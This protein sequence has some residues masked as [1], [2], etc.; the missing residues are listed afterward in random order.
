M[1]NLLSVISSFFL[2]IELKELT[3]YCLMLEKTLLDFTVRFWNTLLSVLSHIPPPPHLVTIGTL[4]H[5]RNNCFVKYESLANDFWAMWNEITKEM[6]ENIRCFLDA[7]FDRDYILLESDLIWCPIPAKN[8]LF[9][10]ITTFCLQHN[11]LYTTCNI[12]HNF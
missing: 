6:M 5:A 12:Q 4:L 7:M 3:F 8:Q 1:D 9:I 10:F 11:F 2:F